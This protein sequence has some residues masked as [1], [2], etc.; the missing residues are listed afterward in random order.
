MRAIN[1]LAASGAMVVATCAGAQVW[2]PASGW[3]GVPA[4]VG[5]ATAHDPDG[6][7]PLAT[8]FVVALKQKASAT[9]ALL[10]QWDGAAWVGLDGGADR[11]SL[12]ATITCLTS[13]ADGRLVVNGIA[14]WS[15]GTWS[16]VAPVVPVNL[17][18]VQSARHPD[19]RLI[20]LAGDR[21]VW[22]LQGPTWSQLPTV[23]GVDAF[24]RTIGGSAEVM[25]VT[26]TGSVVVAGTY[27]SE[28]FDDSAG[29]RYI[30]YAFRW[31]GAAWRTIT[32]LWNVGSPAHVRAVAALPAGAWAIGGDLG[33]LTSVQR[34]GLNDISVPLGPKSTAPLSVRV[35]STSDGQLFASTLG[36]SRSIA[37][38]NGSTWI[39]VPGAASTIGFLT[40]IFAA[41]DMSLLMTGQFPTINGGNRFYRNTAIYTPDC[42]NVCDTID[43][44]GN[45]VYP[46]DDDVITWLNVLAGAG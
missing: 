43:F 35:G 39:D 27:A 24:G 6:A 33:T 5:A 3:P 2:C 41:S 25:T 44:N 15:G 11:S 37:M 22:T 46:E 13:L 4:E 28:Y 9:D 10:Y 34:V 38:W 42:E 21:S 40:P 1:V 26:T 20:V 12:P 29:W 8:T 30:S 18:A 32:I 45:L 31:D 19:G 7:G 16:Q 17:N 14:A 36:A 23:P